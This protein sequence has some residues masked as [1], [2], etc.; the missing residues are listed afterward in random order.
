MSFIN[1]RYFPIY[2]LAFLRIALAVSINLAIPLYYTQEGIDP[3]IIGILASA[4]NMSYIFSPLLFKNIPS[5]IGFKRSLLISVGGFSL[6]YILFQFLL[7]PI[8]CFIL[9]F[10]DG[11]FLGLFWI[12]LISSVSRISNSENVN[13]H[14]PV[15]ERNYSLSWNIGGVAGF[16][17]GTFLLF[18]ISDILLIYKLTLFYSLLALAL[19]F[20]YQEPSIELE[21]INN[22]NIDGNQVLDDNKKINNLGKHIQFPIFLPLF[23]MSLYSFSLGGL[24]LIYPLKSQ[25]LLFPLYSNYLLSFIRLSLQ[26]ILISLTMS[27]S[28]KHFKKIIPILALLV[29]L[30]FLFMGFNTNLILF[31]LFFGLFGCFIS[32]FYVFSFKLIVYRNVSS[33]TSKYSAYYE[34][35][36]GLNFWLSPLIYGFIAGIDV[37]IAFFSLAVLFL[38]AF[39]IYLALMRIIKIE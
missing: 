22:P 19:S 15:I 1:L 5:K 29:S 17:I 24:G 13:A 32:I 27:V 7:D 35:I 33:N 3:Q 20:I 11:I 21:K 38:I 2:G 18:Y 25:T 30:L 6:V 4:R 8:F 37:N 39:F 26:T 14:K 23:L 31:G 28:I 9:L 10:I 16:F 36:V 12:T 34:T